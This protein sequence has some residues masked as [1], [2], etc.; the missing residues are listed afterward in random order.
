[1]MTETPRPKRRVLVVDDEVSITRLLKLN[2]ERT[3]RFEVHEENS[4][5]MA[6]PAARQFQPDIILMDVMMPG[7]GGGEVAA[8]L[9]E[10]PELRRIPVLFLTAAVK[11]AEV[12]GAVARI[13][14]HQYLVKPLNARDVADVIRRTLG[15]T[16]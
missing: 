15:D 11:Q 3:G 8:Q 4:S 12:G 5:L 7:L 9:R 14:K 16:G 2:L 6:L 13:G 10:D 1:M